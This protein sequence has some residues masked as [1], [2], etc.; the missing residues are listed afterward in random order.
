MGSPV[1]VMLMACVKCVKMLRIIP[2]HLVMQ[3]GPPMG[4][5][6]VRLLSFLSY[7]QSFTADAISLGTADVVRNMSEHTCPTSSV[8]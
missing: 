6:S 8:P 1:G 4:Y 5:L 2:R 7:H 3:V